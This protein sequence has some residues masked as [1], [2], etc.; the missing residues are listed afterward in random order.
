MTLAYVDILDYCKALE[1]GAAP[2]IDPFEGPQGPVWDSLQP[3]AVR[4]LKLFFTIHWSF[5]VPSNWSMFCF[6]SIQIY[7]VSRFFRRFFFNE[8]KLVHVS[9][10]PPKKIRH[11]RTGEKSPRQNWVIKPQL[12]MLI[13][14]AGDGEYTAPW[15]GGARFGVG[16][17]LVGK[18]I[19]TWL[20]HRL[21]SSLFWF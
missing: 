13:A 3:P 20:I 19:E 16:K 8:L 7:N 10:F 12:P 14:A 21:K 15:P 1:V 4:D 2:E 17:K 9:F 6:K 11:V 5:F 18:V